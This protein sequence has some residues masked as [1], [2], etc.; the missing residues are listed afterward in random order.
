M[1]HFTL[2]TVVAVASLLSS[3]SIHFFASAS[4][5]DAAAHPM[6]TAPPMLARLDKRAEGMVKLRCDL[7]A[8]DQPAA[9]SAFESAIS[10]YLPASV[11]G[12]IESDYQSIYSTYLQGLPS[13]STADPSA[14]DPGALFTLL[15]SSDRSVIDAFSTAI[16]SIRQQYSLTGGGYLSPN[17]VTFVSDGT[18]VAALGASSSAPSGSMTASASS[19]SAPGSGSQT[20]TSSSGA[21]QTGSATAAASASSSSSAASPIGFVTGSGLLSIVLTVLA[22]LLI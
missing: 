16:A 11:Y 4:P 3:S 5:I 14:L 22:G 6:I 13:S 2:S 15:P 21:M 20:G 1:V 7:K 12:A 18:T 17:D 10:S 9:C 19:S 8:S